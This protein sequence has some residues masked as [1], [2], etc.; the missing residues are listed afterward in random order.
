VDLAPDDAEAWEHLGTWREDQG[1]LDDAIAAY[2]QAVALSPD[3]PSL[4]FS[5]AE[6]LREAEHYDDAVQ[7]YRVLVEDYT[8]ARDEQGE[9]MLADAYTG[10][11]ATLNIAGR[12]DGALTV[13]SKF[14]ERFPD[15]AD[16]YYEQAS[17]FDALGRHEEAI[18]AYERAL[19]AD[20]LN[21]GVYS[22]LAHSYLAVGR[23]DDATEMA[24]NAVALDPEFAPAYDTLAQALLGAG[25]RS[26]AE[27]ALQRAAELHAAR[28][29]EGEES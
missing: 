6:I 29:D 11:A 22:D 24:E 10:L 4:R 9:E 14:L 2:R 26:E 13:A 28:A 27:R 1:R 3:T 18:Q 17:A 21:A 15:S 23:L 5:L 19:E 12:Y 16:A 25:R 20:P 7:T 8:N